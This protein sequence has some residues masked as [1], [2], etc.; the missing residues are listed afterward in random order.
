MKVPDNKTKTLH[1]P[2]SDPSIA[3]KP[4]TQFLEETN[5]QR[6]KS[7]LITYNE[8]HSHQ[9]IEPLKIVPQGAPSFENRL[10]PG[11]L[12]DFKI[13]EKLE[14][15]QHFL[16][17]AG[18]MELA[19]LEYQKQSSYEKDLLRRVRYRLQNL[20]QYLSLIDAQVTVDTYAAEKSLIPTLK[21]QIDALKEKIGTDEFAKGLRL[22][23]MLINLLE[24]ASFRKQN[25]YQ[26]PF[27]HD[28][29]L[30]N[31]H[32]MSAL[33]GG[34]EVLQPL[35]AKNDYPEKIIVLLTAQGFTKEGEPCIKIDT[36][37]M[38]PAKTDTASNSFSKQTSP[39]SDMNPEEKVNSE[40]NAT[41]T[42]DGIPV[43][44]SLISKKYVDD[45]LD[46]ISELNLEV[47]FSAGRRE[48]DLNQYQQT[49]EQPSTP[50]QHNK[51]RNSPTGVTF[52]PQSIQIRP[53]LDVLGRQNSVATVEKELR[54][55]FVTQVVSTSRLWVLAGLCNV[56]P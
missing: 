25:A 37:L 38:L 3:E 51:L 18:A 9:T 13:I 5:E 40:S 26:L 6:N 41:V 24:F 30:I 45:H 42:D 44:E 16:G 23:K 19:N 52:D 27:K 4:I 34:M 17:F 54:S 46:K 1:F 48:L 2:V 36:R 12:A 29:E 21:E 15:Q 35:L 56:R 7:N 33:K 49:P 43:L 53:A 22:E 20:D 14:T 28:H 10:H 50:Q 55:E 39:Q 31:S 8:F 32:L 11:L 47:A